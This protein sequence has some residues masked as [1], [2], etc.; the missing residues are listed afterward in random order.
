[1]LKWCWIH[2]LKADHKS[3]FVLWRRRRNKAPSCFQK[4]SES[5]EWVLCNLNQTYSY[6]SDNT[7]TINTKT[8]TH[9]SPTE[10][11][12]Y[13]CAITALRHVPSDHCDSVYAQT[14]CT[15]GLKQT[16]MTTRVC[17]CAILLIVQ[18]F[19]FDISTEL[20]WLGAST[21]KL[22]WYNIPV[23]Q[24]LFFVSLNLV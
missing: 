2:L 22:S 21:G 7:K 5:L 15:L 20:F 11:L 4:S 10:A 18:S 3:P 13:A 9:F 24:C 23:G 17:A 6:L 1:M 19:N 8:P 14:L 12:M 16:K